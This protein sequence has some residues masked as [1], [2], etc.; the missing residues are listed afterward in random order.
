M[1]RRKNPPPAETVA[2]HLATL[3]EF[4]ND[5]DIDPLEC[6]LEDLAL[7]RVAQKLMAR[8]ALFVSAVMGSWDLDRIRLLVEMQP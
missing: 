6:E 1:L 5:A 8:P 3:A 4:W 2:E 7:L